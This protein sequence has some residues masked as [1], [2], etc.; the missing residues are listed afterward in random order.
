M[1]LPTEYSIN[2]QW[3]YLVSEVDKQVAELQGQVEGM[4]CC[5]N[6]GRAI[7][8]KSGYTPDICSECINYNKWKTKL[9]NN[10]FY[11]EREDFRKL[12]LLLERELAAANAKIA[13]LETV[14]IRV[15]Q[16][17]PTYEQCKHEATLAIVKENNARQ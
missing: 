2:G 8:H 17:L 10:P 6:C 15:A 13:E 3:Y 12:C 5:G 11:S 1:K 9:D 14:L 16:I 4:K 7:Q